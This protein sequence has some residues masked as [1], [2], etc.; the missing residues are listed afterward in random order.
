MVTRQIQS[1]WDK[2]RSLPASKNALD[3]DK[4]NAA[5]QRRELIPSLEQQL[6]HQLA[7]E[8]HDGPV[9]ALSNMTMQLM[10]MQRQLAADPHN[11]E[12]ELSDLV[13]RMQDAVREMRTMM[14]ELRPLALER[15][16]L[17]PALRQFTDHLRGR[18]TL[19][20]RLDVPDDELDLPLATQTN[21]FY[22][23]QEAAQNALKHAHARHLRI[24][25]AVVGEMV[26]VFVSDDGR[27]FEMEQV[28][29]NYAGRKS[30]GL[31]NLYER[32]D[33][34]RGKLSMY[35]NPGEGTTVHLSVPL[36]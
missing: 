34:I 10:V 8:L 33:L 26:Q 7:R 35:S 12:L 15:E 21:I 25:L 31:V 16:G 27:G 24:A 5:V 6:R 20:I 13:G 19:T 4:E 29:D 3:P 23:V 14:Y 30:L 28:Q 9:Q 36:V 17:I 11:V 2:R 18:H 1:P 32:A 22:I